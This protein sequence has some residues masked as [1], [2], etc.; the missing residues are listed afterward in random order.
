GAVDRIL[1]AAD[2][3]KRSLLQWRRLADAGQVKTEH[4]AGDCTVKLAAE[5][6]EPGIATC[7]IG[8][9]LPGRGELA[10][11]WLVIGA[12]YDHVGFG[13]FGTAPSNRGQLHPGADDN[14]SGTSA[15]LVLAR[16]FADAY[17]EAPEDQPL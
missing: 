5:V 14:A 3:Q 10:D 13:H 11:E 15:L 12:H 6:V 1:A 4:P 7:N 9:V 17:R 2:P 16:R 8:G